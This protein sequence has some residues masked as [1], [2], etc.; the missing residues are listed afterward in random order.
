MKMLNFLVG[1][2]QFSFYLC[3][4]GF[5][6]L[7]LGLRTFISLNNQK[8]LKERLLI[9]FDITSFSYYHFLTK[10]SKYYKVYNIFL[11]VFLFFAF[12][13]FAFGVHMYF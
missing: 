13:A 1:M 2:L 8:P 9:I 3:L 10:E 4:F 12:L 5:V 11:F 7:S 6:P